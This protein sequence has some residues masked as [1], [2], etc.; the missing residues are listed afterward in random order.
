MPAIDTTTTIIR[1]RVIASL[2]TR[3]EKMSV[4]TPVD[5]DRII[6][7]DTDVRSSERKYV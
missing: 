7:S 5:A 2:R 6:V 4:H 3:R 1:M